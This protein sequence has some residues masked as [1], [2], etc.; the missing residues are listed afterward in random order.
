MRANRAAPRCGRL[1]FRLMLFGD[2]AVSP[3]VLCSVQC[4]IGAAEQPIHAV[5][6][7]PLRNP[8]ARGQ[9]DLAPAHRH[10]DVHK[11]VTQLLSERKCLRKIAVDEQAKFLTPQAADDA[12][13]PLQ[14]CRHCSNGAVPRKVTVCVVHPLEFAHDLMLPQ[15]SVIVQEG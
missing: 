11:R 6:L 3:L 7:F 5:P 13:T 1:R 12:P 10:P 14:L 9:A 8:E 4:P 2:D 15:S